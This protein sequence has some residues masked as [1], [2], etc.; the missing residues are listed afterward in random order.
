MRMETAYTHMG[1]WYIDSRGWG[2]LA[3]GTALHFPVPFQEM[4]ARAKP[5][6]SLGGVGGP[7]SAS[8]G[9]YGY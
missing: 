1:G 7:A 9:T 8:K 5:F 3:E 4:D 2:D 6:Y